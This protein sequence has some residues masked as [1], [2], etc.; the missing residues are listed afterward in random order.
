MKAPVPQSL[1]VWAILG[2][3]AWGSSGCPSRGTGA[4]SSAVAPQAVQ[5]PGSM[6]GQA[7]ACGMPPVQSNSTAWWRDCPAE[8][9]RRACDRGR[10]D[11]CAALGSKLCGRGKATSSELAEAIAA[12]KRS[13]DAA[14]AIGCANLGAMYEEGWGTAIDMVNAIALYERAC[15][16]GDSGGCADL[17]FVFANGKGVPKDDDRAYRLYRRACDLDPARCNELAMLVGEGRGAPKDE[18]KALVIFTASCD[19]GESVACFNAAYRYVEGRVARED[20]GE[21]ERLFEKACRGGH[22]TACV[23]REL[24]S[25]L[26]IA[27]RLPHPEARLRNDCTRG[28]RNACYWL[29][30]ELTSGHG[31]KPDLDGAKLLWATCDQG[32]AEACY[33]VGVFYRFGFVVQANNDYARAAFKRACGLGIQRG[34]E[35]VF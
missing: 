6:D 27:P 9:L 35:P 7:A 32:L 2:L 12:N 18:V 15:S 1:P 20:L 33:L 16:G 3:L 30:V 28:D 24:I 31:V 25:T 10:A 4:P 26:R 34:C 13:C 19:A 11:A 14:F 5:A 29:G 23:Q 21:A 8:S 17:G 22:T